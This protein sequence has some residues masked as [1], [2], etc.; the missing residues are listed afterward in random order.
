MKD[1]REAIG[2]PDERGLEELILLDECEVPVEDDA[3]DC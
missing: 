1:G 2:R 3:G